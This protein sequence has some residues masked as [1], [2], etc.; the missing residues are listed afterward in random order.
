MLAIGAVWGTC[1]QVWGAVS[2]WSWRGYPSESA[3]RKHLKT[4]DRHRYF[5]SAEIDQMTFEECI[6]YHEHSHER[7]KDPP[8]WS[9]ARPV[10]ETK[11]Y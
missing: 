11:E 9:R 5:T 7:R 2:R 10:A 4:S 1:V 6:A 8:R 3:L